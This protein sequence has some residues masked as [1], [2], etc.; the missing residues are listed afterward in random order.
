MLGLIRDIHRMLFIEAASFTFVL[1]SYSEF[2]NLTCK[3]GW[4]TPRLII[5]ILFS[6][7]LQVTHFKLNPI[8]TFVYFGFLIALLHG[9]HPRLSKL[10]CHLERIVVF[11]EFRGL[12]FTT[13]FEL[14][15]CVAAST[16]NDDG[17]VV[18]FFMMLH[19]NIISNSF[20]LRS[21]LVV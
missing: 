10:L 12:F 1:Q 3:G 21:L 13:L 5:I 11:N 18:H 2:C 19:I 20:L 14:V 16:R 17:I 8:T 6:P 4:L 15:D 7:F 9:C